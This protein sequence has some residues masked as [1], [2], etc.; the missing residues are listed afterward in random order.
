MRPKMLVENNC[1]ASW[2]V[3]RVSWEIQLCA[4]VPGDKSGKQ[5]PKALST[6]SLAGRYCT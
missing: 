2:K 4:S 6:V 3:L 1:F 5:S